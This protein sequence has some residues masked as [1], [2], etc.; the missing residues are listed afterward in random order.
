MDRERKQI[1]YFVLGHLADILITYV[2]LHQ[3]DGFSEVGVAGS[4]MIEHE[5]AR[6]LAT[7]IGVVA[8]MV[9]FFALTRDK[10][11]R[12]EFVGR[13]SIEISSVITYLALCAN[14]AQVLP[15]V[16]KELL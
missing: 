14:V 10:N 16:L 11:E 6:L 7:K 15:V 5:D 8:F 2:A 12:W 4:D 3:L 1:N 9:G 13:R